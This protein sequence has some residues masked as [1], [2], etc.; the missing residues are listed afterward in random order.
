MKMLHFSRY[1]TTN[2]NVK[3]VRFIKQGRK[4]VIVVEGDF[5]K[6]GKITKDHIQSKTALW[7]NG[8]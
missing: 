3:M 6:D 5:I 8:K 2:I 7:R 1:T 4:N